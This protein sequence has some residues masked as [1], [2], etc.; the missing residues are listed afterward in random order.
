MGEQLGRGRT[1]GEIIAEMNT[2]AEGVQTSEVV[3]DLAGELGTE[4]PISEQVHAVC[5]LGATARDAYDG[6]LGRD[7]R[8]EMHGIPAPNGSSSELRQSAHWQ[9]HESNRR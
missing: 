9:D 2:V 6:V 7:N 5:H 8:R 3:M 1:I 4:M